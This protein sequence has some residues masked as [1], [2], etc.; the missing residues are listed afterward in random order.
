MAAWVQIRTKAVCNSD[1]ANTLKR[2]M[3]PTI[4]LHLWVIRWADRALLYGKLSRRK[5][6]C[7]PVLDLKRDGLCH[8]I[9]AQDMV[10]GP[11]KEN[12]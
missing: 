5:T 7:K 8:T 2:G 10:T 12:S 1:S 6:E 3:N 4:F 9:P 11:V